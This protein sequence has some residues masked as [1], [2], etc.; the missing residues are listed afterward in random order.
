MLVDADEFH[1]RLEDFLATVSAALPQALLPTPP[2]VQHRKPKLCPPTGNRRS[3]R[4]A[5]K[6]S[7]GKGPSALTLKVLANKLSLFDNSASSS[8]SV[9]SDSQKLAC[10][11][12]QTLSPPVV[13][14]IREL[15][16]LGGGQAILKDKGKRVMST[17]SQK[18]VA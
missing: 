11:F 1:N 10:L 9:D 14:A 13:R 12:K 17:S 3:S 4:L 8:H 6:N 5:A 7:D 15:V 16:K 18:S 2:K